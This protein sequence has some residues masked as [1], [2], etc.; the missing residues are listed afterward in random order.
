M[1]QFARDTI[2]AAAEVLEALTHA[3]INRFALQHGLD[4]TDALD[5]SSKRDRVNAL[6]KYLLRRPDATSGD[7]GNLTDAIVRDLVGRVAAREDFATAH[8]P[9]A[10]ALDRD[11]F[12]VVDRALRRAL[13][14][15]LNLPAAD[16]EVHRLL[17][18]F[19]FQTAMG[20]LDQAL[21]NHAQ[22]NWASAN[23]Q[24][25]T[26][27]ESLLD[28]IAAMLATRSGDPV[29]PTGSARR[30]Y[31]AQCAPP[32]LLTALNEWDGQ[33]KGFL[34]GFFRRLHP[35]GSHPGLSDEDDATFRL[36]LVLL[37]SRLLLLRLTART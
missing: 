9:L 1:S 14:D 20:H 37:V 22:A 35:E 11:G 21:Q 27:V 7:G 10:R 6:I 30:I 19:G 32:F 13:P 16:D 3:D 12:V 26:F 8:A 23:G 5:G 29:P 25:R 33:G 18:R 15:A 17:D 36:H 2:I 24:L 28:D 31:L 4:G 34:Q